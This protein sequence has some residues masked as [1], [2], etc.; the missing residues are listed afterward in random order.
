MKAD[1]HCKVSGESFGGDDC[2]PLNKFVLT[3]FYF[4]PI[5][6]AQV[7]NIFE[8]IALDRRG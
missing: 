4:F 8:V 1:S 5:V 7:I 3:G 2:T 6:A